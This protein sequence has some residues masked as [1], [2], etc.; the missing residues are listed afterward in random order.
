MKISKRLLKRI[1]KEEAVALDMAPAPELSIADAGAPMAENHGAEAELV[2][3]MDAALAGLGN[4]MESLDSAASICQ[5][6][7]PEVAAQGPILQ[8]V[9][10]QV[11]ALQET[12]AAVEQIVTE[13]AD[14]EAPLP[15][16]AAALPQ[17]AVAMIQAE[18]RRQR[19]RRRR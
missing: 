6:C 2:V 13:S 7:L 10:S 5:D 3:E 19:R 17:E 9:A 4:V 15:P 1:I 16:A 18:A 11:S 8:A 14:V 12:L